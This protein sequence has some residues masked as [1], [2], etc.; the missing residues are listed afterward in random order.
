MFDIENGGKGY[1]AQKAGFLGKWLWIMFWLFIPSMIASVMVNENVSAMFPALYF[2][3][4]ILQLICQIAYGALLL[5]VSEYDGR[6]KISGVILIIVTVLSFVFNYLFYD[7]DG[8]YLLALIPLGASGLV[9]EY[10]EYMAHSGVVADFDN[11][12]SAK[13]KKLWIWYIGSFAV[14]LLSVFAMFILSPV[15]GLLVMLVSAIAIIVVSILKLIYLYRTAKTFRDY[16]E[17][18]LDIMQDGFSGSDF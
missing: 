14:F 7:N 9:G 13:W 12:I 10:F 4:E 17:N 15:I 6:Y 5:K 16:R 18:D 11:V 1:K 8:L 2:P 3:G